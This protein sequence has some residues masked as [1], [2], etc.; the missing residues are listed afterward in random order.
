MNAE[1][2]IG[3]GIRK[4]YGVIIKMET[5]KDP[6]FE[7]SEAEMQK[8]KNKLREDMNLANK[9]KKISEKERLEMILENLV[10]YDDYIKINSENCINKCGGQCCINIDVRINPYDIWRM[11]NHNELGITRTYEFF[12]KKFLNF[13]MSRNMKLPMVS[14]NFKKLNDDLSICPFLAPAVFIKSAKDQ[15]LFQTGQFNKIFEKH[16]NNITKYLCALQSA[17]PTICRGSPLG[18]AT[19]NIDGK[20]KS[21]FFF[22][23]PQPSC[24]IDHTT[25]KIKVRDYI[26]KMGLEEYYK[27]STKAL[28]ILTEMNKYGDDTRIFIGFFFYNFDDVIERQRD[29]EIFKI[30]PELLPSSRPNTFEELLEMTLKL[31]KHADNLLGLNK[32]EGKT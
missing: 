21:I 13:Y 15:Y 30:F 2:I 28:Q 31:M 22:K 17:K 27:N 7:H 6:E 29:F 3:I 10:G 9:Y 12:E 16:K 26:K 20:E 4:N 24:S 1:V 8:I 23:K 11:T 14:I 18:R 32:C 25:K 5:L 19:L